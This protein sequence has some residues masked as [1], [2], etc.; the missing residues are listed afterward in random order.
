M[1]SSEPLGGE[2]EGEDFPSRQEMCCAPRV[3]GEERWELQQ[4][5][6]MGFSSAAGLKAPACCPA[7]AKELSCSHKNALGRKGKM[8]LE[9]ND[10]GAVRGHRECHS[11]PSCEAASNPSM[12]E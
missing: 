12:W 10:A 1:A 11:W 2:G 4:P 3:A 9:P 8:S 5:S 6:D 7:V